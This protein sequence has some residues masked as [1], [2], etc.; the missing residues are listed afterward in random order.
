MAVRGTWNI[1]G[2]NL[3][4]YG[5]T[6]FLRELAGKQPSA[7]ATTAFNNPLIYKD[8]PRLQAPAS[9]GR[10]Q[11]AA[12]QPAPSYSGGGS[13][14]AAAAAP[15]GGGGGGNPAVDLAFQ[16]WRSAVDQA[17]R[18]RSSGKA[19]F[20]DLIKSVGAFRDRAKTQFG[21]AGQ[22]IVNTAAETLGTNA[23]SAE[24]IAGMG[25]AQGRALGLGD[26]SRFNRQ[27]KVNANLASTQGS[28]LANKGENERA[29]RGV[30]DERLGQ[31]DTQENQANAYLRNIND[32]ASAVESA[33]VDNY[34]SA[35]DNIIN[36]QRQLAA[37]NPLQAGSLKQFAPDLSSIQNTL[38]SVLG[39]QSARPIAGGD[40]AGNLANPVDY[41]SLLKQRGLV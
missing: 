15:S 26:S 21:D 19:T 6:E 13:G 28:V 20:D 8:T 10:V 40:M 33:G 22:Q 36:Y 25:R 3:P 34:G 9:T 37:I 16:R 23:R 11:G 30:Y 31:A 17:N 41:L 2:Y 4:D 24:E 7:Q 38:S 27:Q 32:S 14:M 1:G 29:N 18:L 5:V 12:I 39:A 35:L